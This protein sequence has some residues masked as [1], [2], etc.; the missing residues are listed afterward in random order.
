MTSGVPQGSILGPILFLLYI[1]DLPIQLKSQNNIFADD[2]KLYSKIA[3]VDDAD[4]L[5]DDLGKVTN[6]CDT[7]GM[8]LNADKCHILHYGNKNQ[9]FLYH[10]NG[11]LLETTTVEKDLGVL[12]SDTLKPDNHI[13]HCIAKANTSL[14]MIRRTFTDL[15]KEI[16]LRVYK[17]YVRPILEYCQEIW[18][19]HLAV[20]YTHLTLPTK[21]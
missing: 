1:N 11:T 12:I 5:Q 6:W 19:P 17:V 15:T 13:K 10:L 4:S 3:N 14:G 18:A 16:F 7:W 21:A 2:T 8:R 20:S 9:L